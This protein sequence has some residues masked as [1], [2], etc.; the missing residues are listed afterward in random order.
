MEGQGELLESVTAYERRGVEAFDARDWPAAAAAFR[1]GLIWSLA[2]R[3]SRTPGAD[4]L[5][6]RCRG[7]GP[8]VQEIVR[9][10][11]DFARPMSAWAQS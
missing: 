7:C 5:C 3:A 6:R 8:G 9:R 11:P 10:S 1:K 4:A 2:I